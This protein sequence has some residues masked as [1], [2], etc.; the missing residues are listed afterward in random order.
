MTDTQ[1]NNEGA[2]HQA[3]RTPPLGYWLRAVDALIDREFS[4]ALA[5]E[6]VDRRD[7]MMLNAISGDVDV[8]G[9]LAHRMHG[10]GGKR[11]RALT[12]RGW[13]TRSD[14]AWTLTD[15]GRA[16]KARLAAIV[17]GIRE[18][19]SGAV[20]ADDYATM[21][22]S[23]E[24]IAR[25]LGGDDSERMPRFGHRPG[26]RGFG[27]GFGPGFASGF[28]PRGG[29]HGA[30]KHCGSHEHRRGERH[31]ERAFERGFDAGF[32]AAKE[33]AAAS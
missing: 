11:L 30:H 3:R 24:A 7:W 4:S 13:V 33:R 15:D 12:E 8:P 25:E 17:D 20:S 23:L 1:N 27:P 5:A 14:D 6:N 29:H 28:G 21:T 26:H 10:R 9:W 19:V 22:A 32:R 16:A 18:R 31:T 2:P